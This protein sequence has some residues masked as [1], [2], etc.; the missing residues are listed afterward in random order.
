MWICFRLMRSL[1]SFR[2]W[3]KRRKRV[4]P[5]IICQLPNSASIRMHREQFAV[6]L[7]SGV[8][9]QRFVLPPHS[10]TAEDNPPAVWRPYSVRV[11]ASCVCQPPNAGA[12]RLDNV[13][14]EI[15][16]AEACELDRRPPDPCLRQAARL[17]G[18]AAAPRY[19]PRIQSPTGCLRGSGTSSLNPAT[20]TFSP[21]AAGPRSTGTIRSAWIGVPQDAAG[22]LAAWPRNHTRLAYRQG[23][24]AHVPGKAHPASENHRKSGRN[25]P[26]S[27]DM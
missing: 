26:E 25:T 16:V 9:G 21:D 15:A 13:N 20:A 2:F 14:L 6:G 5:L 18:R 12:V 27:V 3:L 23:S 17:P 24:V 8:A 11:V 1:S 7:R 4:L 22:Y 19:P 10:G